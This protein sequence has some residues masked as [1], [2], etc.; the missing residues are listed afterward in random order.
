MKPNEANRAFVYERLIPTILSRSAPHALNLRDEFRVYL[1]GKGI[2]EVRSTEV[3]NEHF[4][5]VTEQVERH[6]AEWDAQ[7]IP[8]PLAPTD[9]EH[10]FVVWPHAQ[11]LRYSG[12]TATIDG[13]FCDLFEYIRTLDGKE[14]LIICALWLKVL[15]FRKI[16]ICDSRGD[17]G[18]DV[19]GI[20][21][22]GGLSSLVAVVQAKTSNQLIGRGLVLSEYG[23]YMMLPHTEKYIQYRR[24]LDID[25]RIEGATWSY[26]IL[27]N[28]SFNWGARRV[29]SKL[30]IL[31]RSVHQI[32]FSLANRYSKEQIE[33]EVTRL[34]RSIRADLSLNFFGNL[35]I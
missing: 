28:H 29:A 4:R 25:A 3:A 8:R 30:G 34:A 19:L 17:E 10:I 12:L 11:F 16:F 21:E 35:R 5:L 9:Q 7:G 32:T 26:M 14:F 6:L 24:A 2:G 20:L 1:S 23:K 27:A 13:N 15:G 22:A 31:L 33:R 18:V